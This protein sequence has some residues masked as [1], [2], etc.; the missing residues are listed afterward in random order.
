M[1]CTAIP[2]LTITAA[3]I[4]RLSIASAPHRDEET[5][6]QLQPAGLALLRMKLNTED[7]VPLHGGRDGPRVVTDRRLKRRLAGKM[8]A[9]I[10][11]EVRRVARPVEERIASQQLNVVPSDVRNRV[12]PRN[13]EPPNMAG[14]PPQPGVV[15]VLLGVLRHE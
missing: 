5:A 2:S 6:Q 15:A 8:V 11:V 14:D 9:V 1:L 4:R 12:L 7:V 13:L 3:A 10:E